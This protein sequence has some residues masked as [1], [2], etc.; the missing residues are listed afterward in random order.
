MFNM[1]SMHQEKLKQ[2]KDADLAKLD[3]RKEED[4]APAKLDPR[5]SAK[6]NIMIDN[7]NRLKSSCAINLFK[8]YLIGPDRLEKK[9]ISGISYNLIDDSRD[10]STSRLHLYIVKLFS[11]MGDY[12]EWY[13]HKKQENIRVIADLLHIKPNLFSGF[14][15]T[16]EF[17]LYFILECFNFFYSI[18]NIEGFFKTPT[19]T[20]VILS[21]I[22]PFIL[23]TSIIREII[24]M[25]A[26][27]HKNFSDIKFEYVCD[28]RGEDIEY[29]CGRYCVYNDNT[30]TI[31]IM[32]TISESDMEVLDVDV[33]ELKE[34]DNIAKQFTPDCVKDGGVEM[35]WK[36]KYIKY[37][38]KYIE[39]SKK[40][41][42][43]S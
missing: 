28:K 35:V 8:K 26:D 31:E 42:K 7:L 11:E 43:K 2:R 12:W 13:I 37:K 25:F 39:L 29:T 33:K 22:M 18:D 16:P 20:M 4:A 23:E 5:K 3:P 32:Q 40:L 24:N 19:Y 38:N 30:K 15:T 1:L 34:K 41:S 17:A 14:K 21:I 9:H 36:N 27:I 10:A 6:F